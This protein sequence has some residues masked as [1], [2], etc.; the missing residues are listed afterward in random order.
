MVLTVFAPALGL[1]QTHSAHDTA[2]AYGT[3]LNAKG[4]PAD[5]NPAHI[6]NRIASRIDNRLDLRIERYRPEATGDPG[7]AFRTTVND[8]SRTVPVIAPPPQQEIDGF[9]R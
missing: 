4:Q 8:K 9:G 6:N 3:R 2:T 5:R 1:A 7:A